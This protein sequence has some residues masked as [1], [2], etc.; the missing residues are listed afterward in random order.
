M[1]KYRRRRLRARCLPRRNG[2][3]A[4]EGSEWGG[5]R[6]CDGRGRHSARNNAPAVSVGTRS[7]TVGPA[8]AQFVAQFHFCSVLWARVKKINTTKNAS[9]RA[10][11]SSM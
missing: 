6:E 7:G 9:D 2:F 3:A 4:V 11:G 8:S 5:E 1:R 10:T